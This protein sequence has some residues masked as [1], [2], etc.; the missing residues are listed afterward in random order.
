[1][2]ADGHTASLFPGTRALHESRR[3]VVSNPVAKLDTTR[4]TMTSPV[5][6]NAAEVVFLVHGADKAEALAA[7]LDGPYEPDRLP[8]QLIHPGRGR[9]RWLVD[10]TAA[11]LLSNRQAADREKSGEV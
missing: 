5:L 4:I 6:N 8:A 10:P 11:Q 9:L 1:M 3:W 7:V 2:G